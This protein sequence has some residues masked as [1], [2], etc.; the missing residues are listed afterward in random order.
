MK[1][2][3][4]I[5]FLN[6]SILD[7]VKAFVYIFVCDHLLKGIKAI[8]IM[9][10]CVVNSCICNVII[11]LIISPLQ[12]RGREQGLQ[13]SSFLFFWMSTAVWLFYAYT[14]VMSSENSTFIQMQYFLFD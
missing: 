1:A 8:L 4:I 11:S 6:K 7:V 12:S 2:R 5:N 3:T 9:I 13:V 14:Y 10:I